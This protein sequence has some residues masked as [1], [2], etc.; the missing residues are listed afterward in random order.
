MAEVRHRVQQWRIKQRDSCPAGLHYHGA[1]AVC[2]L[3]EI[4]KGRGA[5]NHE[6]QGAASYLRAVASRGKAT[7]APFPP[8]KKWVVEKL[9]KILIHLVLQKPFEEKLDA[10]LKFSASMI[11]FVAKITTVCRNSVGNSQLFAPLTFFKRRRCLITLQ[12]T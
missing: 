6:R 4:C 9:L 11:I 7:I 12:T 2:I 1:S 3:P 8:S 10:K 5:G